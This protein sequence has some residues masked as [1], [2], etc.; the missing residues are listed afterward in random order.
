MT[1][2][3]SC[4]FHLVIFLTFSSVTVCVANEIANE[5]QAILDAGGQYSTADGNETMHVRQHVS[6]D[7]SALVREIVKKELPAGAQ[8]LSSGESGSGPA[9]SQM[10]L[11]QLDGDNRILAV[12]V[13][14][15]NGGGTLS[16]AHSLTATA[17]QAAE[18]ASEFGAALLLSA[19]RGE[20]V[21]SITASEETSVQ[22]VPVTPNTATNINSGKVERIL[23]D[24][25]YKYGVGGA[26][27]PDY[28]PIVLFADG[29]VCKCLEFALDEINIP[30]VRQQS[31]KR[32]GSWRR[33]GA[34]YQV[35]WVG[36]KIPEIIKTNRGTPAILPDADVL[37][38][39]YQSIGGGG[40]T[41]LGGGT[42]TA[43]TK[44]LTFHSDGSFSQSNTTSASSPA[45]AGWSKRGNAGTWALSEST[46]TLSYK[47]GSAVRTTLFYSSTRKPTADYGRYGVLWIGGNDFKRID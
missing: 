6:S 45:G 24:L 15:R 40:N 35:T 42:I 9:R 19:M 32:V 34:D 8:I 36:G 47:D 13:A 43:A 28:A 10:T 27:Y 44:S 5:W 26:A 12:S 21:G 16:L 37:R 3:I 1:S 2:K 14:T 33:S 22:S 17:P 20:S 41:A 30:K 29:T 11:Y 25:D 46:L 18:R 31:P 4:V 7:L 38:G 39:T 23:F